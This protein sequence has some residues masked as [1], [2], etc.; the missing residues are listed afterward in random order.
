MSIAVGTPQQERA[1]RK[2]L[3]LDLLTTVDHKKIGIMYLVT[4]FIFFGVGGIEALLIRLQLS[5]PNMDV[6]VGSFYNQ[7]LTAHGTTMQFLFII[8]IAAGF[9]NYFIPLMI[10][11]R[12]MALPR[13]NAFAYWLYL[14][15]GILLYMAPLFGGWAEGGWVTYFPFASSQYQ[16]GAGV[17]TWILGLQLVGFAS[18]FAGINFIVTMVNLRTPGMGWRQL[19]MFGW[20][21]M[22]TSFLQVLATPGVTAATMIT[23]LDRTTGISLYNAAIGGD[24]VLYQHLFW[25][26]SHP[27]V[28]IM[29]LPWFGIVSEILPTFTRKPIFG[30]TAL[31]GATMGIALVS[32]LVWAHHM[33]TSMGSPILNSVFAFTTMLVAVP[34]GVK[35][36]NW[37]A[38]IWKGKIVFNTAMLM[39][40]GFIFLFTIGG[41][42]GVAL[43]IVPFTWQ[44][45]DTYWVV[46]HFH[47][48]LIGG[49]IF[50]V[51][52]G[53]FYWFPKMTG[54]F[55]NERMGKTLFWLWFVG[56]M[57][58]YFPQ[59]I[60]GLLGMPRRIYT[61]AEGLGWEVWNA[62]SSIGSLMLAFGFLLFVYNVIVSLRKPREA[63]P[64]PWGYGYS[65][66]W[67]TSSPPPAYNFGVTLPTD[68]RSERPLYD[69]KKLG[70]WPVGEAAAIRESDIHLPN[71]SIWPLIASFGLALFLAGM[72]L[73]GPLWAA[74]IAVAVFAF[75]MWANEPAFDSPE[76]ELEVAHHN[77][78]KT[79]NGMMFA[80]WFLGSEIALFLMVFSAFFYLLFNGRMLFPEELPSIKLAL[81]NTLFLLS[82]SLTVHV[83]HHDFN[84]GK[85]RTFLGLLAVTIAFG[86]IFLG[87]TGFEWREILARADPRQNL[88]LSAFFTITGLHMLHVI[89][90]LTMLSVAFVRGQ[91]RK[92]TPKLQNGLEVPVAYWHLVDGVWV[93]VLLIVYVLPIFYQGPD[94]VRNAGDPYS[95]YQQ[96]TIKGSGGNEQAIPTMP[97]STTPA[98]PPATEAAPGETPQQLPGPGAGNAIPSGSPQP[99]NN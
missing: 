85:R 28:Y 27:A 36:F 70:L 99:G 1:K 30:Y 40:L 81:L 82:S 43:A 38:T 97:E 10:G 96:N 84:H 65:L 49:S 47:N 68:F 23:L 37:L 31:A 93:F 8:P 57:V 11:A 74:G 35:I 53:T 4:S 88:Y 52:A 32:Y 42:T 12:D 90:G 61:Y 62:I 80:Y 22:A 19:P 98:V 71:P 83:S 44:M 46:A 17:D 48:I 77:R 92:F 39:C 5:R 67:A 64:N 76:T 87:I 15:G 34:T 94:Q 95:V 72:V 54:R 20:A 86:A 41:I 75:I 13:M 63:G 24:P 3:W 60:L 73:Q 16:P 18:I 29:V 51:M 9:G 56:F 2:P 6:L 21:I 58:T 26:Y 7:I 69:W 50:I 78:T 91:Q 14:F 79:P 66:E 59:Y 33:F 89:A 25:F 55:L 45:H